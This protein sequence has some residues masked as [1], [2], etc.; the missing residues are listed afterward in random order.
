MDFSGTEWLAFEA[1]IKPAVRAMLRPEEADDFEARVRARGWGL[2]TT[3][4]TFWSQEPRVI[5]YVA[6]GDAEAEAIR[7]AEAPT[8]PGIGADPT[9]R[10]DPAAYALVGELLG[11]PS[12]CARS[13]AAR[14]AVGARTRLNGQSAEEDFCMAE[15]AARDSRR[16][17]GRLNDLLGADE[18]RLIP[19]YPCR[20]D[21]EAAAAYAGAVLEEIARRSGG[22]GERWRG[23][24]C[25]RRGIGVSGARYPGGGQPAE[26][27]LWIDFKEL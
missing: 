9:R 23:A 8:L 6:R 1:G 7:E 26:E 24:L 19:F 12:C 20:Y 18:P 5:A 4:G 10:D 11:Y 25:A 2:S 13:Y 14:L 16:F 15:K 27:V 21:C 22:D 3:A 17:L